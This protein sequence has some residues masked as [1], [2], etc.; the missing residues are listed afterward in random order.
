MR[1][2]FSRWLIVI[3][4]VYY[5][6]YILYSIFIYMYSYCN[7][8]LIFKFV[9]FFYLQNRMSG[10]MV[11]ED[12][13]I[14]LVSRGNGKYFKYMEDD[15]QSSFIIIIINVMMLK[16]DNISYCFSWRKQL[17]CYRMIVVNFEFF[18][19][20]LGIVFMFIEMELF[21]QGVIS[22]FFVVFIVFKL[23]I[24]LL[25]VFFLIVVVG[26]YVIG[27]QFCMMDNSLE[28]WWLVV[29]FLWIY[30]KILFEFCV[31]IIYFIFGNI[32]I[33]V[34]DFDGKFKEVLIDVILLILMFF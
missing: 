26:Y 10:N 22:K 4:K 18:F 30:L 8:N 32:I 14:F 28:D 33:S 1:L 15:N 31:C 20:F 29:I 25:I 21:F 11:V 27:I 23:C 34:V 7:I 24:I 2:F 5:G 12:L 13:G 6:F 16:F 19:V 17:F 9:F 3:K